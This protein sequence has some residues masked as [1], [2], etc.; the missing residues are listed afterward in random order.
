MAA[1]LIPHRLEQEKSFPAAPRF[2]VEALVGTAAGAGGGVLGYLLGLQLTNCNPT[3]DVCGAG[4]ALP[5]VVG[6][7]L[8]SSLAVYG[9]GSLLDGRGTLLS[10][11]MG[12]AAGTGLGL[13]STAMFGYGGLLA[14]PPLAALG[15]L[16]A[17]E[18]SGASREPERVQLSLAGTGLQ[19]V[20]VL[21]TTPQGGFLG[22]LA[23]R[24]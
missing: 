2:M 19:L 16:I 8:F 1:E 6:V 12:G 18:V 24:F 15:A 13:L 14:M 9:V 22:G 10:A 23:G 21:G 11:M 5:P 3:D 4:S 20:P 7:G 17:F